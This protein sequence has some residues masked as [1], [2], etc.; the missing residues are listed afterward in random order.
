MT[1]YKPIIYFLF[2][3][4][5]IY[6]CNENIDPNPSFDHPVSQNK[7]PKVEN[8][9]LVFGSEE[10]L[11]TFLDD[12]KKQSIEE[13]QM[14]VREIE[15][16]SNF[17]SLMPT[18]RE[19]EVDK[20]NEYIQFKIDDHYKLRGINNSFRGVANI[21]SPEVEIDLTEDEL[22]ADP[23]FASILNSGR[24][25]IVDEEVYAY[26]R[27]GVFH[28]SSDNLENLRVQI[29]QG[30]LCQELSGQ[31]G[32]ISLADDVYLEIIEPITDCSIPVAPNSGNSATNPNTTVNITSNNV[33]FSD[34]LDIIDN[35]K[36]C[37]EN[38]GIW[39][40]FGPASTCI[41]YFSSGN[42]RIKTKTWSQNWLVYKSVG[43]KVKGQKKRWGIWVGHDV[44]ELELGYS[45]ASFEYSIPNFKIGPSFSSSFLYEFDGF[46]VDPFGNTLP[47][48]LKIDFKSQFSSF[49][50]DDPKK[51]LVKIYF[52]KP[53]KEFLNLPSDAFDQHG[54]LDISY[55]NVNKA[56]E[57][58]AENAFKQLTKAVNKEVNGPVV[59]IYPD[60]EFNKVTFLYA[61][62]Y[63]NH[64]NDN[65]IGETLAQSIEFSIKLN[66]SST[67]WSVKPAIPNVQ[68]YDKFKIV[69]YGIG[70]KENEWRGNKVS[71]IK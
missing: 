6:S 44:S 35:L 25:L 27:L 46:V 48:P 18:F 50:F 41:D 66:F 28:T 53:I 33:G 54:I 59:M 4:F 61:N 38:Q 39:S 9:I 69:A 37:N 16:K 10:H 56:L 45:A 23:Y 42:H 70:R 22:I 24:E 14:F 68:D 2:L 21:V 12:A 43:L 49:P 58:L 8:G 64:A 62:W 36:D 65:H 32:S 47:S 55:K 7:G 51:S 17:K 40:I 57:S 13:F 29:D 26:N 30:D 34:N 19:S 15:D 67:S 11:S 52:S 63:K 3:G 20:R 31:E 71:I 1:K 60:L 5:T